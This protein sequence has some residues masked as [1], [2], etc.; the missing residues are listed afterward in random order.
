M[1]AETPVLVKALTSQPAILRD[2]DRL[3]QPFADLAP[4]LEAAFP[5]QFPEGDSLVATQGA[6]V[7]DFVHGTYYLNGPARF[8]SGNLVYRHWLDGDGRVCALRFEQGAVRLTS[9]YV[10]TRKFVEEQAAGR[11]LFRTFGTAFPGSRLNC[12]NNGLESPA[13]VSVYPIGRRLLAFG[14]QGLPWEI[15]P[16]TLETLGPVTFGG[17]LNDASPFSAHPKFDP[18][19]EEMFNFGIFFSAQSPRLYF[20][21]FGPEGLRYRKA[22]PLEDP[23]SVH[24]FAIS[25]NYAIFYLSPYFLDASRLQEEQTVMDGLRWCPDRG[26]RLLV[27]SRATGEVF[28]SIPLE[29]RYCLHLINAF[30][31]ED[32]L[33]VDILEFD[34]PLYSHYQPVPDLFHNVSPGGPVRFVVDLTTR[35]LATRIALDYSK[36]PDFPAIDPACAMRPYGEFWMLGISTASNCGR[37]FFDQLVH[38]NWD[39]IASRDIYQ[40]PS[41]KYLAGEPAFMGDPKSAQGVLL[42]QEFDASSKKSSFLLFDARKVSSGPITRIVTDQFQHL[43]FHAVFRPSEYCAS[44][45]AR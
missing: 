44:N 23:C 31:K 36:A 11:P 37:K 25:K 14:E 40:S 38:L 13:N 15:D 39:D 20:Y 43:G 34:E 29:N 10:R 9:R 28:A 5:D 26:S 7:P 8:R 17:R 30:E 27:L 6:A 19:T 33:V 21:C 16:E 32:R 22:V 3:P 18:E 4:G 35:E 42:C 12:V 24:D 45:G 2:D 1:A 41:M